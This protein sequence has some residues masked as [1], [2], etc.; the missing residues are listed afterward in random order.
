MYKLGKRSK[1]RLKGVN[2]DLVAVVKRAI[3]ITG[4]D[5]AV[6]EGLRTKKRQRYLKQLGYSWTL[7]SKHLIGHAVDLAPW[8]IKNGKGTIDWKDIKKFEVIKKAMFRA[9]DELNVAI[10]WGGD[11]NQNGDYRDEIRRGSFDGAH[12]ELMR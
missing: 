1:D 9:A 12:F 4:Q 7:N 10:R 2:N 3:E 5:F 8:V 6:I 11:W